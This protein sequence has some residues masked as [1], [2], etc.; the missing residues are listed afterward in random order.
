MSL[1][2]VYGHPFALYCWKVYIALRERA[3]AYDTAMV[4]AEHS[5]NTAFVNAASPMGQF[6]VLAHD[7]RV[8]VESNPIIEYLDLAF[9][10]AAPMVPRDRMAAIEARQM[11]GIFDDY[12]AGPL[13]Q[14][15]FERLRP[16]HV[17]DPHGVDTS[18][19][20]LQRAY[21]WLDTW[22]NGRTWAANG[23]FGV[24]ECA[25]GPALFYAHWAEEIPGDCANL[26]AYHRRLLDHPSIA[27][28]INDARP[29]R[30]FF[31]LKGDRDPDLS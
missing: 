29:M 2:V 21:R 13:Q 1:P 12:I 22:M 4:D 5:E 25:A 24:A 15:V 16:D 6:P 14:I 9:P 20:A 31:P 30:D 27:S 26:R 7:G 3:V 11:A 28:V 18:R 17:K 8:V 10:G 23:L 19:A